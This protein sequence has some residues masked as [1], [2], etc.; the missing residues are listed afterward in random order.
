MVLAS[1]VSRSPYLSPASLSLRTL[2]LYSAG[3]LRVLLGSERNSWSGELLLPPRTTSLV[4][5]PMKSVYLQSTK[6]EDRA[7][8]SRE[9]KSKRD[10]GSDKNLKNL[11][12]ELTHWKPQTRGSG[13]FPYQV[14]AGQATR[15]RRTLLLVGVEVEVLDPKG[16]YQRFSRR[17]KRTCCCRY[18]SPV[19]ITHGGRRSLR[20][21]AR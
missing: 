15:K 3:Q 20:F 1:C 5:S 6:S 10:P 14:G 13:I 18:R 11:R 17:R 16:G 9:S 7:A 4:V 21:V 2:R 19:Q 8:C 12:R